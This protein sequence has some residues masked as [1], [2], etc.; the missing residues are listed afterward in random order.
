M[1]IEHVVVNNLKILED[2]YKSGILET[3]DVTKDFDKNL[4]LILSHITISFIVSEISILEAV[5]LKKFCNG[6]L[7]DLETA[8]SDDTI[9]ET[10]FPITN[11]T[12]RS[13]FMLNKSIS[14]DSDI[15]I[16]PG[17]VYFP[18]KIITKKVIATFTGQNI[19]A[20]INDITRSSDCFFNIL[21][22][23]MK[24]KPDESKDEIIKNIL[25][26]NFIT[27]FYK[28]MGHKCAYMDILSDSVL[29]FNYL[30]PISRTH[31][32]VTLTHVS[33]IYG[34]IPFLNIDSET[35]KQ[36]ITNITNNKNHIKNN[37]CGIDTNLNKETIDIY[38]TCNS[39]FYSFLEMFLYLPM[40]TVLESTDIKAL[41]CSHNVIIPEE[42]V[43]YKNRLSSLIK[44]ITAE[45]DSLRESSSIDKYNLILLNTK[46]Q[47]TLKFNLNN[48][49]NIIIP[50][51]NNIKE[52]HMYGDSSNYISREILKILENIRKYSLAVFSTINK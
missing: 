20:I 11:R 7:I 37:I 46:I 51:E 27:E 12:V 33:S 40:G 17:V 34:E 6:N 18:T 47:F 10:I 22:N 31:N 42:M 45:K 30:E 14:E 24:K 43:K 50:W 44:K 19:L 26:R 32:L 16:K 41:Y 1:K 36:S 4:S 9:D 25:I 39:S 3:K 29:N 2:G 21:Y 8:I 28:F 49:S 52:H 15:E 23:E 5:N 13:L 38:F 48:I 35:Y